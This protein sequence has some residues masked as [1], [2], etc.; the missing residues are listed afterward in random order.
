MP[1][2]SDKFKAKIN[3]EKSDKAKAEELKHA[4]EEHIKGHQ[5]EDPELYERFS[6]KLDRL[7]RE[8]KENWERIIE[9]FLTTGLC[10][11]RRLWSLHFICMGI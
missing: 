10:L 6:E 4:I 8:Y 2:F 3:Q 9:M 11:A 7:L 1:I 5:E